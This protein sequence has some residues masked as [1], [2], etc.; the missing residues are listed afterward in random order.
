M[1][2][3]FNIC[4]MWMHGYSCATT[5]LNHTNNK[6]K[7]SIRNLMV[8][9]A[10]AIN[11]IETSENKNQILYFLLFCSITIVLETNKDIAGCRRSRAAAT[12]N[13]FPGSLLWGNVRTSERSWKLDLGASTRSSECISVTT[14]CNVLS[15]KQPIAF[16][17]NRRF[18]NRSKVCW[19]HTR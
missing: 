17:R 18:P 3:S 13:P 1:K 8:T 2:R 16:V 6:N 12:S 4:D 9:V 11:Q 19:S 5:D 10:H 15:S 14:L 7:R